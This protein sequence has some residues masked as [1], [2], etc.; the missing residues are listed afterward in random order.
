MSFRCF[1][2]CMMAAVLLVFSG[3]AEAKSRAA[4][5]GAIATFMFSN[6]SCVQHHHNPLH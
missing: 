6:S 4:A 5:R 3:A 2:A 1:I